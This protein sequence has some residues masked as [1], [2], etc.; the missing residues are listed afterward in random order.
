M[1]IDFKKLSKWDYGLL[2]KFPAYVSLLAAN[3]EGKMDS[4]EKLS[5]IEFTHVKTY[6]S[7]P[8][9]AEFFKEVEKNFKQTLQELNTALPNGKAEREA[10]IKSNLLAIEDIVQKLNPEHI[11]SIH[12]SMKSF[13]EHVPKAHNNTL[14]DFLFPI[15]IFQF[16]D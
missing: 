6:S 1:T 13:K 11:A 3:V 15:A 14:T 5:A 2:L 10:V 12:H 7:D 16:K 4:T 9:L 8:L